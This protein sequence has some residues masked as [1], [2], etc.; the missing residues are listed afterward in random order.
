MFFYDWEKNV[1][2]DNGQPDPAN[3][4]RHRRG[5]AGSGAA[6]RSLFESVKLAAKR[7]PHKYPLDTHTG[8]LLRR[9]REAASRSCAARRRPRPR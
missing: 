4:Q 1:L 3:R 8:M 9:R 2:G 5:Q 7:P 6:A